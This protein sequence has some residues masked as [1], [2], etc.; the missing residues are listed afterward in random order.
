MVS[1]S[2]GDTN[3]MDGGYTIS[4]LATLFNRLKCTTIPSGVCLS[5]SDNSNVHEFAL[6]VS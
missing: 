1:S 5:N 3:P 4:A 6:L 2:Q